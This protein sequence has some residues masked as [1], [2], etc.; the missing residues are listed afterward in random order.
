LI[1]VTG[2]VSGAPLPA[3]AIEH[4]VRKKLSD[5]GYNRPESG[6]DGNSIQ[7][8]NKMNSQS[9]EIA[10]AVVKEGG[11]IGAGD[12]GMMFG[13]ACDE[14]P[15]YMPLAHNLAFRVINLLQEEIDRHRK[16]SAWGSILLPDAKSQVTIEYHD[17]HA[18][19]GVHTILVSTQHR[20]PLEPVRRAGTRRPDPG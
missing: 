13:Y 20:G 18:P 5:I 7:I 2:E 11:E 3:E 10:G 8:L 1:L 14:T 15:E 4:I 6:Y 17:D 19:R 9:V 12:Q 16:G